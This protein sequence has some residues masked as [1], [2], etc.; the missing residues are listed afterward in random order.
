MKN[1]MAGNLERKMSSGRIRNGL[2][3]NIKIVFSTNS[4]TSLRIELN[5]ITFLVFK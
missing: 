2:E 3:D 5:W 1:G 4:V